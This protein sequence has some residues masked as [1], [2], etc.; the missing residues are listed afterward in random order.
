MF[1]ANFLKGKVRAQPD[2]NWR[3]EAKFKLVFKNGGAIEFAQGMVCAM[4]LAKQMSSQNAFWNTPPPSYSAATAP[5]SVYQ[6]AP[7]SYYTAQNNYYGWAPPAYNFPQPDG[8]RNR[9]RSCLPVVLPVP[10][11]F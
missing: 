11:F 2:G 6:Q 3:G 10:I 4:R 9:N 1:G 8:I 7:P 5:G